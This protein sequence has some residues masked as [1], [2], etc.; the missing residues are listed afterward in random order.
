MCSGILVRGREFR[1]QEEQLEDVRCKL[2]IEFRVG[3]EYGS[4]V[5]WKDVKGWLL[6]YGSRYKLKGF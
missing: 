2:K 1:F 3:K 4:L 5:I 6:K